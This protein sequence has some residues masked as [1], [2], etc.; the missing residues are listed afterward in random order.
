M[1]EDLKKCLNERLNNWNTSQMRFI[2]KDSCPYLLTA[3]E[4]EELV[5]IVIDELTSIANESTKKG[6]K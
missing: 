6:E 4:R 2:R 1:N 5:N 3:S